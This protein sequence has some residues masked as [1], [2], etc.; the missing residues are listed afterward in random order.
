M[1]GRILLAV[2]VLSLLVFADIGP[3]PEH[4]GITLTF[5]RDGQ[6]YIG[7]VSVIYHCQ[8]PQVSPGE[9]PVDTVEVELSCSYGT[10]NNFGSWFYK[11]NPCFDSERGYFRY[12]TPED[13]G[14]LSTGLV[15]LEGSNAY[16]NINLDTGEVTEAE[17][18]PLGPCP[19]ALMPLALAALS[20]F[21]GKK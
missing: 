14:Y 6:E 4:T 16:F 10:C 11:F 5:T 8:D 2:L 12:K 7:P 18:G 15:S 19:I 9:G 17:P 13:A 21:L 3:V 1:K 20:L